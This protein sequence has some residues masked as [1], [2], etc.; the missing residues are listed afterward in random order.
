MSVKIQNKIDVFNEFSLSHS[1][2]SKDFNEF[3]GMKEEQIM[4]AGIP[5]K[6]YKFLESTYQK[7]IK[8]GP[9]GSEK[10]ASKVLE[11]LSNFND[12]FFWNSPTQS[13]KNLCHLFIKCFLFLG[14]ES[15]IPVIE[16]F[17]FECLTQIHQK[18][19]TCIANKM[20]N[21]LGIQ[22]QDFVIVPEEDSLNNEKLSA[23]AYFKRHET[24]FV[25]SFSYSKGR[26]VEP[27]NMSQLLQKPLIDRS[28]GF[29]KKFIPLLGQSMFVENDLSLV[30]EKRILIDVS[31]NYNDL[32]S[33]NLTSQVHVKKPL[34]KAD[35]PSLIVTI[36][37][38]NGLPEYNTLKPNCFIFET[39]ISPETLEPLLDLRLA[40]P[41][42]YLISMLDMTVDD[43]QALGI[44]AQEL[45]DDFKQEWVKE[46][47]SSG[48]S[49]QHMICFPKTDLEKKK[50]IFEIFLELSRDPENNAELI[51]YLFLDLEP[52]LTIEE[53]KDIATSDE[54][55]KLEHDEL[56]PSSKLMSQVLI[57]EA[58]KEYKAATLVAPPESNNNVTT[59]TSVSVIKEEVLQKEKIA[60]AQFFP[61][62]SKKGKHSKKEK[63]LPAN[64]TPVT[65][66][67]TKQFKLT[68]DEKDKVKSVMQGNS[69]RSKDFN[70]FYV[71]L[72]KR[73]MADDKQSTKKDG[74]HVKLHIEK[75]EGGSSGFT[76]VRAHGRK[77]TKG[78]IGSQKRSLKDFFNS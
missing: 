51:E 68:P 42:K 64:E 45:I 69:M 34:P 67:P 58:M 38:S 15:V 76:L 18:I 9:Q 62:S 35:L 54:L 75:A 30:T 78:F 55:I 33:K 73:K 48:R 11:E 24:W 61:K 50:A 16:P 56:E 5:I 47:I 17:N 59:S 36:T 3:L 53:F 70:K 19:L 10:A 28:T 71:K 22:D 39:I 27:V 29:Q 43:V 66:A 25:S 23:H 4:K 26:E 63:K 52:T 49:V 37:Y 32:R 1:L 6:I 31:V 74:S 57:K 65:T 77:D 44:K 46:F 20:S 60:Q 12:R 2:E 21:D 13:T 7:I 40:S 8:N 14:A 41:N 72:L